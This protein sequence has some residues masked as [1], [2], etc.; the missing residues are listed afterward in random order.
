MPALAHIMQ[1][2]TDNGDILTLIESASVDE[3][4]LSTAEGGVIRPGFN[5]ELDTIKLASQDGQR[6]I[7][8]M[9]QRERRRSGISNLKVGYNKVSGYYIEVTNSNL[10]RVPADYIRKQTLST[11]ERYITADLKEYETLILNAQERISKLEGELFAQ[12]R[13]DI[14]IHAA[15]PILDTAHA[16]AEI[17]VYLSLAEVAAQHGYCRPQLNHD[18]TIHIVAARHPVVDQPQAEPPFIPNDPEIPNPNT[19]LLILTGPT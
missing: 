2:L 8:Q 16:L 19:Q 17:D 18:D 1:Q 10:N 9:E 7:T 4:P 15:E 11:G 12:L 6:W 3:P 14:A 13:A 5:S